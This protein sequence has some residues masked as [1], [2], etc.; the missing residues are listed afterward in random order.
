MKET[1]KR[2]SSWQ[3]V[4]RNSF[5]E[6]EDWSRRCDVIFYGIPDKW[7]FWDQTEAFVSFALEGD[8]SLDAVERSHRMGD[9]SEGK[10]LPV[11]MKL[12]KFEIK[13]QILS[14]RS[15]L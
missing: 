1:T 11:N 5:G 12:D 10:C 4:L 8:F 15:N 3:V 14:L 7:E 13:K 2:P 6:F 9:L